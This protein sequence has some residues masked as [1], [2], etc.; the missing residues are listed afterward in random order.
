MVA[1]LSRL[2]PIPDMPY[3]KD[4]SLRFAPNHRPLTTHCRLQNSNRLKPGTE[5]LLQSPL[6][7]LAL[8]GESSIG[9]VL[10]FPVGHSPSPEYRSDL[11]SSHSRESFCPSTPPA[12]SARM[13]SKLPCLR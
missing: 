10:S 7:G 5:Q 1:C 4:R 8:C 12:M 3:I 6:G 9:T 13:I 2:L 11:D